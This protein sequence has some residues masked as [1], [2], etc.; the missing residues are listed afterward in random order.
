V[1]DA[2]RR[3]EVFIPFVH[4]PGTAQVDFEHAQTIVEGVE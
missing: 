4:V 2:K 3:Q 1:S